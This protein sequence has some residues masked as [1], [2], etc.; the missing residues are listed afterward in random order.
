MIA[1]LLALVET[2]SKVKD[3][4]DLLAQERLQ[5]MISFLE[6]VG[7]VQIRTAIEELQAVPRSTRPNEE[8]SRAI[9]QL[10]VAANALV[11]SLEQRS[12]LRRVIRR[13]LR[14]D[15]RKMRAH[16]QITGCYLMVASLYLTQRNMDLARQY[17]LKAS[18]AF[19]SY[20]AIRLFELTK[21]LSWEFTYNGGTDQAPL[22]SIADSDR[23]RA[24]MRR[25]GVPTP[26]DER[27]LHTLADRIVQEERARTFDWLRGLERP[28]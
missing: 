2:L 26:P 15:K 18:E 8:R 3:L 28:Q 14:N 27:T 21:M 5:A 4:N 9:G 24:L 12:L 10:K 25:Y 20:A 6:T 7:E 22:V 19:G 11:M 16:L 13:V 17:A 1:E 23:L